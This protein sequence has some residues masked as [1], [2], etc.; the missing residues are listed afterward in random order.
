MGQGPSKDEV[1]LM[2]QDLVHGFTASVH[3]CSSFQAHQGFILYLLH[4][5]IA[6]LQ[7]NPTS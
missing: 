1:P 2:S 6:C 4:P 3:A 5:I 7:Y